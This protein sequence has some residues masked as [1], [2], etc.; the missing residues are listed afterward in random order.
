MVDGADSF[1][2][3]AQEALFPPA[4]AVIV[5]D[6]AFFAVTVPAETDA[7]LLSL[8]LQVTL[9]FVALDAATVAVRDVEL[10]TVMFTL[11]LSRVTDTTETAGLETVT[12]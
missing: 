12:L 11:L 7:T 6:P 8:L 5:A 2:V 1:T 10:P 9:L 3:T 4:V